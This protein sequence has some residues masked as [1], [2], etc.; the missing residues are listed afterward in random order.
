MT[1]NK[2][3]IQFNPHPGT[4]DE[5]INQVHAQVKQWLASFPTDLSN[6]TEDDIAEM[7]AN[8]ASLRKG[9][10]TIEDERKRIKKEYQKPLEEFETKV[11]NITKDID[12]AISMYNEKL[13]QYEQIRCDKKKK[14]ITDWWNEHRNP[15]IKPNISLVW[16]DRYLNKTGI[17]ETWQKDLQAKADKIDAELMIIEGMS[18][19]QL[20]FVSAKYSEHLDLTRAMNE[21]KDHVESLRKTEEIRARAEA[22]RQ[23]REKRLSETAVPVRYDTVRVD[24][25]EVTTES[26]TIAQTAEKVVIQPDYIEQETGNT[27]VVIGTYWAEI[28]IDNATLEQMKALNEFIQNNNMHMTILKDENGNPRKGH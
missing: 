16:D 5:N 11:K 18:G 14:E 10:K 4:V 19:D 27:N 7:K 21:W 20:N 17:G 6:C 8:C 26:E 3:I 28:R 15:I 25:E 1:E 23:E 9:K 24:V 2:L 12:G 22:E 13:D